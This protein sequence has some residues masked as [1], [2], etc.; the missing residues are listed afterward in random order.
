MSVER[1]VKKIQC[2]IECPLTGKD[3]VELKSCNDT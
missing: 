1:S 2:C 3:I